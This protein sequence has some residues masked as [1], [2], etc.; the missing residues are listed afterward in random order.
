ML[1]SKC[2]AEIYSN[3]RWQHF[4]LS[5]CLYIGSISTNVYEP[6]S[7]RETTGFG[8]KGSSCLFTS[9][10]YCPFQ[11]LFA[12]MTKVSASVNVLA[13]TRALDCTSRNT[14]TIASACSIC[15]RRI[16]SS[17][18]QRRLYEISELMLFASW[19]C[20]VCLPKPAKFGLNCIGYTSWG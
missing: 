13:E 7:Y 2:K 20:F 8:L 19:V 3:S 1:S 12:H 6:M 17:K 9:C 18:L 14:S 16:G 15:D 10:L 11:L 4:I 5:L